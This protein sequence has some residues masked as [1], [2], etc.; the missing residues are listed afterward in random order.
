MNS[1]L[2][3]IDSDIREHLSRRSAGRLPDDLFAEVSTALDGVRE[4][5]A[6]TRWPRLIWSAPRLAGAGMGVALVA[7]LAVAVAFPAFQP[8]PAASP[9]GY[10]T[11]RALTTGELARLMAGPQLPINTTLVASVTIDS[12]QDVCPMNSRPTVGVV[13]GMDSQ[14]C[15]MGATLAA[16]LPGPTADGIFAFRYMAPGYLGLLGQITPASSSKIAFRVAED[17]PISPDNTFLVEG[18]LGAHPRSCPTYIATSGGDPLDPDGY[19]QCESNWLT[20]D[21][22]AARS[23]YAHG[24]DYAGLLAAPDG[25]RYVVAGGMRVLDAIPGDAPV[26][27]VY[28]VRAVIAACSMVDPSC[29]RFGFWDVL[30]KVADVPLPAPSPATS[31]PTPTTAPPA[32]PIASPSAGIDVAPT[33]LIGPNNRALTPAELSALTAADS[34]HLAGRYVIDMR[35]T[36]DGV[37]C[38]GLPP[39]AIADQIQRGSIELVGPVD[40]RPDGGLVWTVPQSLNGFQER[41]IFIVDAWIGGGGLGDACDIGGQPCDRSTRL[42]SGPNARELTAQTGAISQFT[43]PNTPVGSDVRGLFLVRRVDNG[44]VCGM[45]PLASAGQCSAQVEILARLE[46]AVLP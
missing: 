27:G 8:G 18:W 10:P 43:P 25:G 6:R 26:H 42:G 1:Q 34:N 30:A 31:S 7:I 36:C 13:E 39:K 21:P 12:R 14:V 3:P 33:G 35:V 23:T 40:L 32:S 22:N 4:P 38:S 17:W 45:A 5:P 28:V 16:Q 29:Q 46:P 19:D 44:K 2:P 9:A 24:S 15:V 41:F 20:D 37:D 11:D